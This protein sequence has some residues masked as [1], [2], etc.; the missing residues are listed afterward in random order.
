MLAYKIKSTT[1]YTI[2]KTEIKSGEIWSGYHK[3][4]TP[5]TNSPK[6]IIVKINETEDKVTIIVNSLYDFFSNELPLEDM[7]LVYKF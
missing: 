3:D 4:Y 1:P 6:N 5:L 2:S 7:Y